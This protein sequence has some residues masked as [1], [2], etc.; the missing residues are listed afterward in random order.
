MDKYLRPSLA[1]LIGTFALVFLGG[2]TV[3]AIQLATGPGH[4][5]PATLALCVALAQG[6]LYAALL[7]ATLPI[8]GGFLN[9]AVTLALWVF[10]RLEGQAAGWLI[11][12]QLLG[13][14]VAA[15][16]LRAMFTPD[17]L[18]PLSPGHGITP[19]LNVD[20]FQGNPGPATLATLL[21]GIGIEVALTFVLTFVIYSTVFDPRSGRQGGLPVGLTLSALVL[22]GFLLTGAAVNPARWL[23]PVLWEVAVMTGRSPFLDHHPYWIG[24]VFGALLGGAVYEYVILPGAEGDASVEIAA[25]PATSTLFRTRK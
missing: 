22:M 2:G 20:A 11:G 19:H 16:V 6:F 24:P 23:G 15:G 4:A 1:E 21:S 13:S 14:I 3:C 8:S 18:F 12:A 9:P 25:P 17:V 10:R 7:S 5:S